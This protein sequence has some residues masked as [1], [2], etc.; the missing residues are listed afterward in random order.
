MITNFKI[1]EL[2]YSQLDFSPEW[3]KDRFKDIQFNVKDKVILN[4]DASIIFEIYDIET[5]MNK[6]FYWYKIKTLINSGRH[7]DGIKVGLVSDDELRLA[8]DLEIEEC[9]I[10]QTANKYNL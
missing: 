6:Y 8:T 7:I 2:K 9:K 5:T 3:A 4:N 1:F 10:Q